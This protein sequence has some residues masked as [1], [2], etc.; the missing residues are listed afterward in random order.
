METD[1]YEDIINL[2]HYVSSKRKLMPTAT[3]AAQFASFAA[4]SGHEEQIAETARPTDSSVELS[5][6]VKRELADKLNLALEQPEQPILTI[7]YF[8]QDNFKEGSSYITLCGQIK[9]VD[10]L[11]DRLILT[12]GTEIPISAITAISLPNRG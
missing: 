6:S 12:D 8:R 5:E 1:N 2:P 7:T 3:R 9:K 4:L 10:K 11:Y